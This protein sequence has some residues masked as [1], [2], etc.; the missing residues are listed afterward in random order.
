MRSHWRSAILKES[1]MQSSDPHPGKFL[2]SFYYEYYKYCEYYS[3]S[4]PSVLWRLYQIMWWSIDQWSEDDVEL[5]ITSQLAASKL[6]SYEI[7]LDKLQKSNIS[8]QHLHRKPS[9]LL[10]NGPVIIILNLMVT[11]ELCLEEPENKVFAIYMYITF[12]SLLQVY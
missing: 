12:L 10:H 4:N 11:I 1:D 5:L 3:Y 2:L 9:T 8:F 7:I 6:T